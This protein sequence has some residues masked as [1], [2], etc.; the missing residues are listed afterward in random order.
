MS[1]CSQVP[2]RASCGPHKAGR[3]ATFRM[4]R[5][6]SRV[7]LFWT[8]P[9]C[10]VRQI[11]G[12]KNKKKVWVIR[13]QSYCYWRAICWKEQKAPVLGE[14]FHCIMQIVIIC[15]G[16]V[17]MLL[18]MQDKEHWLNA[19]VP[20]AAFEIGSWFWRAAASL[21]FQIWHLAR[22]SCPTYNRHIYF[23]WS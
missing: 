5:K 4:L 9:P 2:R 22:P 18:Y 13:I 21:W 14:A 10:V 11:Q 7:S 1:A 12:W 15:K 19:S 16:Q 6:V 8:W 17:N 3:D 20:L 23:N